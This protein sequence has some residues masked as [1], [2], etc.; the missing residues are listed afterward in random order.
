MKTSNGNH[1]VKLGPHSQD[2]Y[3]RV[4]D[5]E[6]CERMRLAEPK[7]HDACNVAIRRDGPQTMEQDQGPSA[8]YALD[9]VRS[10][11]EVTGVD[12]GHAGSQSNRPWLIGSART[13]FKPTG[14]SSQAD[15]D[16]KEPTG[17]G[18]DQAVQSMHPVTAG[19]PNVTEVVPP[20][21][22]ADYYRTGREVQPD[23]PPP[24]ELAIY[25]PDG[26]PPPPPA[27]QIPE[28]PPPPLLPAS[29]TEITTSKVVLNKAATEELVNRMEGASASE[30]GVDSGHAG[31]QASS[32]ASWLHAEFNQALVPSDG[33]TPSVWGETLQIGRLLETKLEKQGGGVKDM[34]KLHKRNPFGQK[35][36]SQGI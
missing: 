13:E 26:A 30:A 9:S 2:K 14:W 22:P 28:A 24:L 12:S 19:L 27:S 23:P 7:Y 6:A 3:G 18:G 5:A 8:S 17:A 16:R 4:R 34:L 29:M 11:A 25:N 32:A 35:H 31:Y 10:I 33:T 1:P 20:P 21:A 15:E 36:H